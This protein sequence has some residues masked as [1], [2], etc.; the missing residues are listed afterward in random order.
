MRAL[1]ASNAQTSSDLAERFNAAGK[2]SELDIALE[3]RAAAQTRI[4]AIRAAAE[5]TRSKFVL[6]RLMG[7]TGD[8]SWKVTQ[9]LPAPIDTRDELH[10]LLATA[11]TQRGD[12]VAA[13]LE[14]TLLDDALHLAKRWRW[15]GTVDVGIE[16][17]CEHDGVQLTGPILSLAIPIFDQG[18]AGISREETWLSKARY[19][20]AALAA[21]IDNSVRFNHA[22]VD[23]AR[24]VVQEYST[25]FNPAQEIIGRRQ[26]QRQN[27][28]LIGQF[29]LLLSKQQQY[30]DYQN[31]LEGVRDYW[32]ARSDLARATGGRLPS[33][34]A[35]APASIGVS[36]A[37]EN[38]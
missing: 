18:Q 25:Y 32:L 12:L 38:R 7:L 16:R 4:E 22:R 24:A 29:E 23:A 6:H 35:I 19:H 10:V 15:L 11:H 2:I 27:F 14:V 1:I 5:V 31:Y 17:D 8:P 30:D 37:G 13:N 9:L 21:E 33:D 34:N 26:Q 28:M 36:D 20:R 3:R